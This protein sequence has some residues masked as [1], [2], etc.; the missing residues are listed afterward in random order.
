VKLAGLGRR[1]EEQAEPYGQEHWQEAG[2]D[3]GCMHRT[4]GKKQEIQ[5]HFGKCRG[6]GRLSQSGNLAGNR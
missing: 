1:A 3:C 4:K 5:W 6:P 2:F